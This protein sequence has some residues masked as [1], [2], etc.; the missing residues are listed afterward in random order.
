[1]Q[2]PVPGSDE[3]QCEHCNEHQRSQRIRAKV[4]LEIDTVPQAADGRKLHKINAHGSLEPVDSI[5]KLRR[6]FDG[7]HAKTAQNLE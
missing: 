5:G 2:A 4:G 6:P 1:M 7:I 3:E